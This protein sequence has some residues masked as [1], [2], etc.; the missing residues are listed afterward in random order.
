MPD[1]DPTAM[2]DLPDAAA[3]EALARQL[4]GKLRKGTVLL[5]S[6]DLGTGKT[7]FARALV[8]ALGHEGE[9]PSPTF[10]LVQ[11]YELE[12]LTL[13]HFDLYRLKHP[14]EIEEIG[15][16]DACAE[17]AVIVEW[18]EKAAGYMPA[19]AWSITLQTK[20]H[21]RIAHVRGFSEGET[22]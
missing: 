11:T 22:S 14:E 18:P 7:T 8:H 12:G 10:T 2:I 16:D 9:V 21:G 17:G 1:P 3:T 15:F 20:G 13:S 19:Q 4:A 5:L 6:G